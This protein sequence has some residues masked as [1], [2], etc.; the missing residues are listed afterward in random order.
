MNGMSDSVTYTVIFVLLLL[1]EELWL[2]AARKFRICDQPNSRSSHTAPVLRGGGVI[3]PVAVLLFQAFFG[4][5]YPWFLAG[6]V[7]VAA[8]SLREDIKSVPDTVRLATHFAAIALMLVQLWNT[9]PFS[10]WL[11]LPALFIG[12]GVLNA[13]N[14][15]DGINGITGVYSLAVIVPLVYL[16]DTVH[17]IEPAYL[18][19]ANAGILVFCMFNF[20]KHPAC[21]AGDVGAVS[22]AFILLFAI[23]MLITV[24]GDFSWLTLLA[25][26]GADTALTICHRIKLHQNI[27]TA[28]REHIYQLMA[29]E[30]K[31]PHLAVAGIYA[32]IQLFISFGLI[33]LPVNHYVYMAAVVAILTAAYIV[34][35]KKYYPLHAANAGSGE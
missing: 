8:V 9:A 5:H 12:A 17:F 1:A 10:P 33:F 13:F 26:Y 28:H 2:G 23:G 35:I 32:A 16:N 19:V 3:F 27:R 15:M 22:I 11:V 29:N 34:F 20:R 7:L 21:F 4:L 18:L 24:T 6:L 30:L 31:I 25:V 14:F